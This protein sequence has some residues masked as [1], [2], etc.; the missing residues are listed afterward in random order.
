MNSILGSIDST[1]ARP[2]QTNADSSSPKFLGNLTGLCLPLACLIAL[3]LSPSET[4]AQTT[5]I[6]NTVAGGGPAVPNSSAPLTADIPGPTAVV[7]DSAGNT[8]FASPTAEYLYKLSSTGVL[9]VFAGQGI[10]GFA[11][12]GG[13]AS[14]ALI[15]SPSG[16][17]IDSAGNIYLSDAVSN[18]VRKISTSGIINTVAG[19]SQLCIV[20]TNPCGDG[21]QATLA[22]LYAPQ[23]LAVDGSGNLYIADSFDN[24]IR[25]VD[26][27]TGI[28][29]TVAGT[30][31]QCPN[32]SRPCGDGGT[33]TAANLNTPYGVAVD[34]LGNLYISDTFDQRVRFVSAGN[35]T[36]YAGSG[37]ICNPSYTSCGDE[38]SP[39]AALLH[40]PKGL[41]VDSSGSLYIADTG[42]HRVRFVNSAHTM[43]STVAGLTCTSCSTNQGFS[44]DGGSPTSAL[45]NF[46][47]S[48][49]L[50]SSGNLVIADTGNQRIRVVSSGGTPII[51]TVAGGGNG[52]DG[53][54]VLAAT[55]AKP[56]TVAIEP[57]GNYLIADQGNNRIRRVNVTTGVITSVAGNGNLG[58]SGDGG[59]A[60]QATLN[61][62]FGVAVDQND[63][64]YIA[65]SYNLVVRK[66]DATTGNI[67]TYAGNGTAC[68]PQIAACGDGGPATSA[69]ITQ[70]TSVSVDGAGNLFITDF[71]GQRVRRVDAATQTI[72]TTAGTGFAGFFGDNGQAT[73]AHIKFPFGI[74]ADT[75]GD[76]FIADTENSRIRRVDGGSGIITTYALNG[77]AGFSGD[78]GLAKNA[79]MG[80]ANEVAID[81]GLNVYIAGGVYNVVRR[82]DYAT[83][84]IATV[85]GTTQ[86]PAISGFSGDGGPATLARLNNAGLSVDGAGNLYIADTGNNRIRY[87]LLGPIAK[88]TPP[89]HHLQFPQ[90]ALNTASSP[91]AVTLTNTG[92]A[93]LTIGSGG[94][95]TTAG[96][97][98]TNNCGTPVAPL[99]K[100]T[101][102]VTFTPTQNGTTSGTLVINDNAAGPQSVSLTGLG[103]NFTLGANPTAVT[104]SVT[105]PGSSTM[106]ITP[107]AGFNQAVTL[108]CSGLPAAAKCTFSPNPI[109]PDGTD[110]ATSTLTISVTSSTPTG[111]FGVTVRGTRQN[112][113]HTAL[114][115]LTVQ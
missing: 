53:G 59:A 3:C 99:Q 16:M 112:V 89:T 67:S 76:F 9:T 73:L 29:T 36:A 74:A 111:S 22:N 68:I 52:G 97:A 15:A 65:D 34:G 26:A 49:I 55:L 8:Y 106:T 95:T 1:L 25:R 87:V 19:S 18:R 44:G 30:G 110:P 24:R 81:P 47:Q 90:T 69:Q 54:A 98:Q 40:I 109:T 43:I 63:N 66:V 104:A 48:L 96:F 10:G 64:I 50:D 71:F 72:T 32:P 75:T 115:T 17:A 62:P 88:I 33:A 35:I 82:V 80:D 77:S 83:G 20:S 84:T 13:Q 46:P 108:S 21:G 107:S 6:I 58:S 41:V 28:I 114:I 100:C 5:N 23:G 27:K 103:P 85:A 11:G 93:N 39:T 78:G 7:R 38:G 42:D 57:S 92:S 45:L 4:H 94:I 91:L 79:A 113:S 61:T 56:L 86:N 105:Q 31:S 12:D 60:A 70:P 2:A 37:T 14:Q 102:E 51:N 101:I